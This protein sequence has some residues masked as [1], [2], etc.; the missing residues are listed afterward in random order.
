MLL[1]FFR[2]VVYRKTPILCTRTHSCVLFFFLFVTMAIA[3]PSSPHPFQQ[4]SESSERD[5]VQNFVPSSSTTRPT[6][7]RTISPTTLYGQLMNDL[8]ESDNS[9]EVN[10]RVSRLRSMLERSSTHLSIP[11]VE[12]NDVIDK[13]IGVIDDLVWILNNRNRY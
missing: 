10:D 6:H 9:T 12:I 11:E 3:P 4:N 8:T 2:V 7:N 5:F 13:L 1:I